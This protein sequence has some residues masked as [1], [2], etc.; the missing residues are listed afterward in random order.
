MTDSISENRDAP[1]SD[2]EPAKRPNRAVQQVPE[3][4]TKSEFPPSE[5]KCC[6]PC[7]KKRDWFD[8]GKI[9]L[10]IAGFAVICVYAAYTIKIYCANQKSADAAK[11]AADTAASQLELTQRPW[12]FVK[13]AKVAS[14]LTFDKDG[15][16]VT[17]EITI[18][19]S[20]LTPAVNALILPKLYP[21]PL[22]ESARPPVERLCDATSY[23]SSTTGLLIFPN[24]D[25]PPQTLTFGISKKEVGD[26]THS[27][28]L[29]ITPFICVLYRPTFRKGGPGYS[30]G[31]QYSLWPTIWPD[32]TT[33]IPV[34]R[35]PL[36]RNGFFGEAAH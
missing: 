19:N 13:D 29:V 33:S 20:G 15:A 2:R 8:Y 36:V 24:T 12:V 5:S 18:H 6:K 27:G 16:H 23:A 21:L 7:E 17:F 35:L 32:K 11:S 10:E 30:S 31:L 4:P 14:P 25:S 1:H 26:N 28:V 22:I 9:G 3:A 34:N